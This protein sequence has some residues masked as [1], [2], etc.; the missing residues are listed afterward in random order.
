LVR[1]KAFRRNLNQRGVL[2]QPGIERAFSEL[3]RR[4]NSPTLMEMQ[5]RQERL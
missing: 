3:R 2:L 1:F 4:R 5:T